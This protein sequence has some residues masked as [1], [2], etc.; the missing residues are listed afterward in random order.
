[1]QR[2]K[3]RAGQRQGVATDTVLAALRQAVGVAAAAGGAALAGE[4]VFADGLAVG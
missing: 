1:M 3:V 2:V 4:A